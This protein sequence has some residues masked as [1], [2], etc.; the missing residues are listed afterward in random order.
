[1]GAGRRRGGRRDAAAHAG[2]HAGRQADRG[3]GGRSLSHR[4]YPPE[5]RT[6]SARLGRLAESGLP[7]IRSRAPRTATRP[8]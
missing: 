8:S 6:R 5:A 7:A 3:P 2:R 4:N 1:M